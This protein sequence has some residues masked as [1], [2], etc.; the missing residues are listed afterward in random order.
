VIERLYE[1]VLEEGAILDWMKDN[2]K[3]IKQLIEELSTLGLLF[4]SAASMGLYVSNFLMKNFPN[5]PEQAVNKI[6]QFIAN[7]PQI[8][9]LIK[10]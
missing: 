8:L 2:K 4:G 9:D 6:V 10:S 1:E 3:V 7:N 5:L